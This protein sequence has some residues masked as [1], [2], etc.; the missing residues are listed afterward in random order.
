MG[1]ET[2]LIALAVLGLVVLILLAK[3]A[4]ARP[5]PGGRRGRDQAS[6]GDLEE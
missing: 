6:L 3:I 5:Q 4:N 2:G 1:T